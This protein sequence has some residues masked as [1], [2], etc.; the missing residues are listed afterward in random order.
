VFK[1]SLAYLSQLPDKF[2]SLNNES[3]TERL[4]G[5]I[6]VLNLKIIEHL[7]PIQIPM[8]AVSSRKILSLPSSKNKHQSE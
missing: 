2:N 7:N 4:T 6:E 3:S 5:K 1:F 8:E